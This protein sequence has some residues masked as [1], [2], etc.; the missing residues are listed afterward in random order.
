MRSTPDR[1]RLAPGRRLAPLG[2]ALGALLLGACAATGDVGE[3][4][5]L[6]DEVYQ[7]IR[8][9]PKLQSSE[10]I[11]RHE[12]GGVIQLNGFVDSLIDQQSILEAVEGVEGVTRV[13]DNTVFRS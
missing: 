7:A 6:V 8:L 12:G 10:I 4:D 11:V 1:R 13:D 9:D 5:P 3:D 2:L